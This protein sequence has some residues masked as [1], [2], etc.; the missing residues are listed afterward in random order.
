M[1]RSRA[2]QCKLA[3]GSIVGGAFLR[4]PPRRPHA[5]L[6]RTLLPDR[7]RRSFIAARTRSRGSVSSA[8][9]SSSPACSWLFAE[10]NRS[11]W[12][13]A[14]AASRASSRSSSATSTTSAGN[15]ID[16]RYCHTSVET[17]AFAGIPPTKTCMNCHSQIFANSP[18]LEPVRESFRTET[19]DR[20]DARARSARFRLLQPQHPRE[21]GGRLRDLPRPGGPHAADVAGAVAA[22]GV[23]PRLPPQSRA[24]RPPARRGVP[25]GLRAAGRIRSSSGARLVAEY[26]IQKLTSCST[27]HR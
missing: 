3:T 11:P 21:Q 9:C 18:I 12:M 14:G 16:C 7:W 17:S 19:L 5:P 20:V 2:K 26:Q 8:R 23:V 1:S 4:R 22:D 6:P 25:R 27:C 10:V 13:T 15:G 24:V